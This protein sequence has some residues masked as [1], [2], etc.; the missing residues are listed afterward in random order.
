M[1]EH[2]SHPDQLMAQALGVCWHSP[3]SD[4]WPCTDEFTATEL[5]HT[6]RTMD[7]A[8]VPADAGE[9]AVRA[10]AAFLR[11]CD[12]D[13]IECNHEAALG[14]AEEKLR[15]VLAVCDDLDR[16][17]LNGDPGKPLVTDRDFGRA[18]GYSL[19]AHLIRQ[20]IQ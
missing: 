18:A 2:R 5:I 15:R 6:A 14:E 9:E 3:T 13:P 16:R 19:A 1:N 20:A 7:A 4:R 10:V 11:T 12:R 17:Y 8:G